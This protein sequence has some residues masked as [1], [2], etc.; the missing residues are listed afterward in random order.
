MKL[1]YC[2]IVP[3]LM[4]GLGVQAQEIDLEKHPGYVDL[5][6]IRIP[7]HAGQ[8]TDIDFGPALL[9]IAGMVQIGDEDEDL[10]KV[11][12][13]LLSIRVKS[14]EVGWEE[15]K[16]IREVMEKI[17]E[18]LTAER[19]ERLVRVKGEEN[20]TNIS[21]KF[22]DDK[23]V[24]FFL[25]SLESGESVTFANIIGGNIDLNTLGKIGMGLGDLDMGDIWDKFDG[26]QPW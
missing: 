19:W 8:L 4:L 9:R 16:R 26:L 17:E 5:S 6:K 15:S 12:S 22:E 23:I 25:M 18:D 2:I 21:V 11:L 1:R 24:G 3:V 20:M 7:E 10:G 13:G 14:Y